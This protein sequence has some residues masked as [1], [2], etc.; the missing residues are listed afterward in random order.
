MAIRRHSRRALL[1]MLVVGLLVASSG[2]SGRAQTEKNASRVAEQI[3]ETGAK[4]DFSD[5]GPLYDQSVAGISLGEALRSIGKQVPLPAD[6][7]SSAEKVILD[8]PDPQNPGDF[9]LAVLLKS[10][11]SL[12]VAPGSHDLASLVSDEGPDRSGQDQVGSYIQ[13]GVR[14][15]D[16]K[17]H[18]TIEKISG[19]EVYVRVGGIQAGSGAG[20]VVKTAV[21]WNQSGYA[22]DLYAPTED[23]TPLVVLRA[24]MASTE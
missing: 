21:L 1:A 16:G 20:N 4:G 24:M 19:R 18:S 3:P 23:S 13:S 17:R 14:F 15:T 10:G 6:I 12:R 22:Y 2:C 7:A 11:I 8:Q 9:V 5:R